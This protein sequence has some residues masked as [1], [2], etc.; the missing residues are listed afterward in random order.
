M[1]MTVVSA[2]LFAPGVLL[3]LAAPFAFADTEPTVD[4]EVDRRQA[5]AIYN[6]HRF[7]EAAA[8]LE[9]VAADFPRDPVV[10][11]AWAYSVMAAA[12]AE[13]DPA[14][15][16][17]E[18]RRARQIAEQAKSM[19]PPSNLLKIVLEVPEDGSIPPLAGSPDVEAAMQAAEAAF[20]QGDFNKALDGYAKVL[21]LDPGN[22]SA[23]LFSG[24]VYYK[25]RKPAEAIA[26]FERATRLDPDIETAHRYWGDALMM[27]FDYEGAREKFIDA[28]VAEPYSQRP[29]TGA[30][31]WADA[32]KTSLRALRIDEKAGP[33]AP[34]DAYHAVRKDWQDSKFRA[35]FPGE[36]AYR[37]SL[38]EERAALEALVVVARALDAR[39]E[40][41]DSPLQ[42]FIALSDHGL[43]DPHILIERADDG[44]ARDYVAYRAISR[45]T[46]QRYFDEVVVPRA[47]EAAPP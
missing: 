46:V 44:I 19:G 11:E 14:R 21:S 40:L 7:V 20:V 12:V 31:Q 25:M 47:P 15:Q 27:S 18:R 34:W 41:G 33:A 17:A 3:L 38:Q 32:V 28:L 1:P 6:A 29:W 43:L 30:A 2:R 13:T 8:L 26:W 9:A 24:D 45:D 16:V 23:M 42:N 37:R 22:Y 35:A 10:Y 4:K 36:P 5:L 39:G